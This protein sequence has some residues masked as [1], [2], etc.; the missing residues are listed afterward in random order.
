MKAKRLLLSAIISSL[1]VPAATA[2][3]DFGSRGSL[4][5]QGHPR[6]DLKRS[7]TTQPDG[8]STSSTQLG[9]AVAGQYFVADHIAVGGGFQVAREW[10]G[11]VTSMLLVAQVIASYQVPLRPRLHLWPQVLLGAGRQ[12]R[13]RTGDTRQP[14]ATVVGVS[15]FAPVV[16]EVA[17][18][19][20]IGWG[21]MAATTLHASVERNG[22]SEDAS[23]NKAF[24]VQA[25]VAGWF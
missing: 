11:D 23:K 18:H 5:I 21:P 10:E 16:L 4:T 22:D 8:D 25:M 9:L 20:L 24:G 6:L 7:T 12:S 14:T 1:L 13:D 2:R 19:F 3:A 15:I 17:G